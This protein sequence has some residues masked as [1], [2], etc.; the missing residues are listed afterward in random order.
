MADQRPEET[1]A[2]WRR[3]NG[4][5]A[6]LYLK[7]T[8]PAVPS[9]Q[10]VRRVGHAPLGRPKDGAQVA[11]GVQELILFLDYWIKLDY[12]IHPPPSGNRIN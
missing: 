5:S 11:R 10:A 2:L 1:A 3:N 9:Q 7:I 6:S 4:S 12:L 8:R